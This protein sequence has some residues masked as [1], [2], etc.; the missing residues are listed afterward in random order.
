MV[1]GL[2]SN[3]LYNLNHPP[4][5]LTLWSNNVSMVSTKHL[6]QFGNER[7]NKYGGGGVGGNWSGIAQE[8]FNEPPYAPTAY[9]CRMLHRVYSERGE[10]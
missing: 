5:R 10:W 4:D 7:E 1:T 9:G 2:L 8:G 3:V 6:Q